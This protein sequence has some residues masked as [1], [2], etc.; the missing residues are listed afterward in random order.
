MSENSADFGHRRA[1]HAGQLGVKAEIILEGDRGQRLVLVL[2]VDAFLG[3]ERLVQALGIAAAFHHA[4][5]ELV[6]DDDLAVAHDVIGVAGE[7]LVRPERLIG[8]VHQRQVVDV[9]KR[10]GLHQ[11]GFAQQGFEFL[12]ARFGER[13]R[14][15]LFVLLVILGRELGD[16]LVGAAI[17]LGGI[18]GRAGDDQGRARLVDQDRIDFVDDGVAERPLHHVFE[19]ELHVVAEV[20]EAEFV[21][22]AVGHVGGIGLAALG[23]G[24]LVQDAADRQSQELVDLAHPLAVALGQIVV[25]RDDMHALAGERVQV[26]RQGRHQRLAFAGLHFGD[27]APVQHDAA[28]QLDVERPLAQRAL[29]RLAHRGEGLGQQLVERFAVGYPF[30][31]DIGARAQIRVRQRGRLRLHPVDLVNDGLK[32]LDEAIVG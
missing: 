2:D 1:G 15:L 13:H 20:I 7:E 21:V 11:P 32:T 22:G 26:N 16:E 29:G 28:H 23:V 12:H 3:L 24:E 19:P 31:E 27:H 8:V 9:V 4:A 25:H 17:E 5:G 18:L 14:A 30:L 6:D 10:A